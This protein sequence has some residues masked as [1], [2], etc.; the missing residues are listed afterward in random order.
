MPKSHK[1][2]KNNKIIIINNMFRKLFAPLLHGNHIDNYVSLDTTS[3]VLDEM[4]REFMFVDIDKQTYQTI[5]LQN[6]YTDDDC[7]TIRI[8]KLSI[9]RV[10][11]INYDKITI[12]ANST[13]GEIYISKKLHLV[14]FDMIKRIVE[15]S[16][17][18]KWSSHIACASTIDRTYNR[19]INAFIIKPLKSRDSYNIINSMKLPRPI[20]FFDETYKLHWCGLSGYFQIVIPM[21]GGGPYVEYLPPY[22]NEKNRPIKISFISV[23][24]RKF[25]IPSRFHFVYG[26]MLTSTLAAEVIEDMQYVDVYGRSHYIP[27]PFYN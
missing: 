22:K 13:F 6:I 17:I 1:N 10:F 11:C 4:E 18:E 19:T 21:D 7:Q 5:T 15:V 27:V 23:Q 14:E 26:E 12:L 24:G 25:H 3:L 8:P 20:R 2:I 9:V 16:K